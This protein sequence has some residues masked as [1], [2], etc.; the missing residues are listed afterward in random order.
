MT[1]PDPFAPYICMGCGAHA[2]NPCV[3]DRCANATERAAMIEIAR[4]RAIMD[5][6]HIARVQHDRGTGYDMGQHEQ[7]LR[8]FV[9]INEPGRIPE[10][11]GPFTST[12]LLDRFLAD[13]EGHRSADAIIT[14]AE[15]TWDL[16]LWLTSLD[17]WQLLKT[18]DF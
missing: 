3:S 17:D 9:I 5:R 15:L 7:V 2:P 6:P 10:K 1:A 12:S 4:L 11:K 18:I 16:D 13:L 14:I 8:A